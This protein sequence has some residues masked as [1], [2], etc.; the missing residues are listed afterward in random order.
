MKEAVII[1][2]TSKYHIRDNGIALGADEGSLEFNLKK[3]PYTDTKK[4]AEGLRDEFIHRYK[5]IIQRQ[6]ISY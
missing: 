5:R 3:I 4:E 2:C 6:R 1:R